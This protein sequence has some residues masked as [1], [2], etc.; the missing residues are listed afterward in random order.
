MESQRILPA[1]P[2]FVKDPNFSLWSMSDRLNE[3][4]VRTWYGAEKPIYG[5]IRT[6]GETYCFLGNARD[7]ANC[8]VRE[9]EQTALGISSFTTDYTFRAGNATL[10]LSFVS[11]V[12]PTNP[13]LLSMP[14]CYLTYRI[15]GDEDAEV[16]LFVN[17]RVAYNDIPE[18]ANKSVRGGVIP[19]GGFEGAFLGLKRQL[20]LSNNNDLIGADWGYWY[21]AGER[22]YILDESDL[23]AYLT[24]GRTDFGNRGEER[25]IGVVGGG[26]GR[27]LLAFDEGVSIDYFGEYL[28]GY[29]LDRHTV[30][31][32]LT[33]VFAHAEEIDR[34][35][36]SF[37]GDLRARAARYGDEYL[38]VL[39][40]SLRQSV[41][42]HKAVTDRAGHL[43]FLSKECGSNGCIATVD[44]SYPSMPLYLLYAPE[45][46]RGMMRPILRFARMPVW[47][48]DFAPHDV[49]TYPSC[50]GQVYGLRCG[51]GHYHGNYRKTG[52]PETHMPLYLLPPAFHPY[53]F[54]RQMPV[55]ECANMLIM[56]LACERADGDR[57]FF[58]ENRDL[59]DKWVRYLVEYGLRPDDQL[60]TDDFAGH[61]K[62]NLN[63]A[64][65]A[66]VGIAA[67]AALT[68]E[69]SYRKIAEDYAQ[70]ISELI[71]SH[72]HSPLTWDS[73]D[74][75]FSLKYNLAFDKLLGLGL[76]SAE[77]LEKEVDGY[78]TKTARY[79][80]PLDSRRGYT[81][82]DWLLWV[83][84]LTD[85]M[86]KRRRIIAPIDGFLR[87]SPDR[88][89]FS[90]WYET[91]DGRHH[92]FI[93]R[94]VVGGCFILLYGDA[95]NIKHV[96]GQHGGS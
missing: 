68:G 29:Y 13:E 91:E 16:S 70:Q 39:Y 79:G 52:N 32:A 67:Y 1:Y 14:V 47:E 55:E 6:G 45:L 12:P 27:F 35:L 20:P 5:F 26:D 9:A 58:G 31:E 60:C 46:V 57:T 84:S 44:V 80:I 71:A 50:I 34:E 93:A 64:I 15:T 19:F 41:A 2:L 21:L 85:D 11:P 43:L 4:N 75:T 74:E 82:S 51:G 18:N 94:S 30:G 37:D 25:Y 73:G 88:V 38:R 49:G 54:S 53:D 10:Y 63:L 66:T 22:A 78:L 72:T 42:A 61:L 92:E 33:Y 69:G 81:K 28:R 56:F 95:H 23:S 40:A 86:E 8:G 36:A 62:N 90:D 89:P 87:E 48:Y 3:S 83:A 76:F 59:C 24:A 65:K 77:L 96:K 17:R 7:W